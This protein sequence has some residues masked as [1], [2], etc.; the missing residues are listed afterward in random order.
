MT[1]RAPRAGSWV[2]TSPHSSCLRAV[3]AG[4]IASVAFANSAIAGPPSVTLVSG[5][6]VDPTAADT[7][8][9]GASLAHTNGL[10][11]LNSIMCSLPRPPA[12]HELARTLSHGGA[13][14]SDQFAANVYEYVN[15]NIDTEFRYGLSKGAF[16]ALL[17]QS[18]TPFDQAQLMV[19]LLREGGVSAGYKAGTITLTGA[20]FQAWSG[21]SNAQAA[22]QFLAD[23][24]VPASVNGGA[25]CSS[26]SGSVSSVTL[27]HIWISANGKLYDPAYKAYVFKVPIDIAQAMGCAPATALLCGSSALSA[28]IPAS[29]QG[30]DASVQANYVQNVS[31]SGLA[32]TLKGY[33]GSL[34]HYLQTNSPAAG[35]QDVVGGRKI[36]AN[37]LATPAAVLPYSSVSEQHSWTGDIPDQYRSRLRVQFDN[38]DVWLY[39]DETYGYWLHI[40]GINAALPNPGTRASA[41]FFERE[42]ATSAPNTPNLTRY[43]LSIGTPT[44][45][46]V[47]LAASTM[48]TSSFVAN[49]T[50]TADHPYAGLSG[51]Y[52][53]QA[54]S[55][56]VAFASNIPTSGGTVQGGDVAPLF[57]IQSWG[58]TG[59]SQVQ[60]AAAIAGDKE[61]RAPVMQRTFSGTA[62]SY[63]AGA[64]IHGDE[65]F[66]NYILPVSS[67]TWLS[68]AG[69]ALDIS[70]GMMSARTQEHHT[71]GIFREDGVTLNSNAVASL[72]VVSATMDM[73]SRAATFNT[74][75]T[76]YDLFEG[77]ASEQVY[78]SPDGGNSIR[79]FGMTNARGTRLYNATSANVDAILA[80][81]TNYVVQ[82]INPLIDPKVVIRNYA[83]SASPAFSVVVPKDGSVGTYIGAAL[84]MVYNYAPLLAY[85]ND[86]SQLAY[87]ESDLQ[88]GAGA[89]PAV[90]DPLHSA[91][92]SVRIAAPG[93]PVT[94]D[95]NLAS[96]GV[97]LTAAPDLTTGV[98]QFPYSLSYQRFYEA[99]G[100][101]QRACVTVSILGVPSPRCPAPGDQRLDMGWH[102]N[103]QIDAR[104]SNDGLRGLGA[105]SGVEAS[106]A[107]AALYVMQQLNRTTSFQSYI[108]TIFSAGWLEDQFGSNV[109]TIH[110]PPSTETF[111]RLPDGTFNPRPG[112]AGT[113]V[114][115][116]LRASII[117]SGWSYTYNGVSLT[118]IGGDGSVLNFSN[119]GNYSGCNCITTTAVMNLFKPDSWLFSEGVNVN[120][121]YNGIAVGACPTVCTYALSSVQNS[122]GRVINI[123]STPGSISSIGGWGVSD[124]NGRS[125]SI[126]SVN[127]GDT[128][129]K[130]T[131]V[132]GQQINITYDQIDTLPNT[133][134]FNSANG[135]PTARIS[136]IS[137]PGN[138]APYLSLAYDSLRR[139]SV[140]TDA[141]GNQ[142]T[143]FPAKVA[144]ETSA[145]G[146]ILDATG[147]L[148]ITNFDY[149]S[150][151]VRNID[152]IGRVIARNYDAVERKI[153]ETYPEG[154]SVSW[155]YDARSNVLTETRTGKPGSGLS[156]STSATYGEGPSVVVCLTP[157]ICNK[158]L[159][160]V[161]ALGSI[162]NPAAHTTSYAW[163]PTT[164][165][166]THI[167]K[168]ADNHGEQPQTDLSYTAYTANGATFQM[169]TS[170]TDWITRH[171]SNKSVL[172]TYTYDATNK[173]V[174]STAT[175]DSG[176]LALRT[177]FKFDA[178]GNLISTS[179]PRTGTCP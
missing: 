112:M 161:D 91:L 179:D 26:I 65:A 19:E 96:G 151:P 54:F 24:G 153:S 144:D 72:S 32:G 139:V 23:G 18:G 121:V 156:T 135:T 175:V 42:R 88:K 64:S 128:S 22:C 63:P 46:V 34:Q 76:I 9:Y 35:I 118:N 57:L 38:I 44:N 45:E 89:V 79:W 129:D 15:H 83:N 14:S 123:S 4:V 58:R 55:S 132:D 3:V 113:V 99:G 140:A 92:D 71:L 168:P 13:L 98:G 28:A 109:V 86:G 105:D 158:P 49:L 157:K 110:K 95:V 12:I 146:A 48:A 177:C 100:A 169:L 137:L 122:L 103:F 143:Y 147:A 126:T 116:G 171:P 142:T 6:P 115:A 172:T 73:Q 1:A 67:A 107:V 145:N 130:V 117:T 124:E 43:D 59:V 75:V 29:S 56:S 2:W 101:P 160:E 138:S 154:N 134:G 66:S 40:G 5:V 152:S 150:K 81:T 36:D 27:S 68:E 62:L 85:A 21:L 87:V 20:Q 163:D 136:K 155:T 33:A 102:D 41:L 53:D 90:G 165:L 70:D 50:L 80:A 114:Q 7:S 119:Y 166:L 78:D 94:V 111:F 30:F 47:P 148:S 37:T 60:R 159:S 108:A 25:N 93:K 125:I 17:D 162:A 97:S 127:R 8:Y 69:K 51:T 106:S 174:P 10:C 84:T 11:T 170:K 52:M 149:G 176:G 39:A 178:T 141:N 82:S 16:G 61:P 120:F 31:A 77:S 164:G 74:A 131:L 167:Y 133:I 104:F 173:Y